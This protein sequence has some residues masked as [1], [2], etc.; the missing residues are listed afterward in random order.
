MASERSPNGGG[1]SA[2]GGG[3]GGFLG[4]EW[5]ETCAISPLSVFEAGAAGRKRGGGWD[6][7]CAGAVRGG[8]GLCAPNFP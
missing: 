7:V 4:A 1:S 2:N 5:A 8:M 3:D 6:D